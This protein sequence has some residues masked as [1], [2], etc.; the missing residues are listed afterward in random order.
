MRI[1]LILIFLFA[2]LATK[3][4]Q[5]EDTLKYRISLKDKVATTYSLNHPH[6]FLSEKAINRRIRQRLPI[7][8]TDLPVC[9]T[10]IDVIKRVGVE[11]VAI[12]KWDN[13]VTVSCNDTALVVSSAIRM[14]R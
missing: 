6:E 5:Q 12:G 11:V 10:Y 4:A 13:F 8:S 9:R 2:S 7:D 3:S 14:A 1:L